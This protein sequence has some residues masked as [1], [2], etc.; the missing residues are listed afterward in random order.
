V[1]ASTTASAAW[2][3]AVPRHL[4]HGVRQRRRLGLAEPLPKGNDLRAISGRS[5]MTC[6]PWARRHHHALQRPALGAM[7]SGVTNVS[8]RLGQL[9]GGLYARLR[10]ML[11][12][13]GA[14]WSTCGPAA[15][16]TM[17]LGRF[18]IQRLRGRKGGLVVRY[19]GRPGPP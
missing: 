9:L 2:G 5:A 7:N 11:H 17:F 13:D 6:S 4:E 19:D 8:W 16:S 3:R 10:G 18:P 15:S 1:I 14:A 12:Y